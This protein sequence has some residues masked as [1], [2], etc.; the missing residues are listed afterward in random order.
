[1]IKIEHISKELKNLRI[2]CELSQAELAKES[3]ISQ[4]LIS[5][6]ESGGHYNMDSFLLLYNY[7]CS[8][9][10]SSLVTGELFKYSNEYYPMII[11]RL[12]LVAQKHNK[13]IENLIKELE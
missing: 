13:E 4:P 10:D 7:Y 12:K 9:M 1:M 5:K 3:G 11:E 6:I 8:R 2:K